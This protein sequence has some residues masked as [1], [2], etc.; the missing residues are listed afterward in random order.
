MDESASDS[1]GEELQLKVNKRFA[2]EFEEKNRKADLLRAERSGLLNKDADSDSDDDDESEDEYANALTP[3]L[4]FDIMKTISMIH[5]KDKRIYDEKFKPFEKGSAEQKS[6]DDGDDDDDDDDDDDE[7]EEMKAKASKSKKK[8][9][10]KKEDKKDKGL[11]YKDLVRQQV[12]KQTENGDASQVFEDSDTEEK[13]HTMDTETVPTYNAEQRRLKDA[14]KAQASRGL[15]AADD[16][17]SD[18]DEDADVLRKKE[19]TKEELE[20]EEDNFKRYMST[21]AKRDPRMRKA[22]KEDVDLLETF[23]KE[24]AKDKDEA[25]LRSFFLNQTWADQ[26]GSGAAFADAANREGADGGEGG[27][28]DDDE[29]DEE[30]LEAADRFEAKYN[31]RHEEPGSTELMETTFDPHSSVRRKESSRKRQ[32]DAKRQRKQEEKE[33]RKEELRRLKNLKRKELEKRLEKSIE[34]AGLSGDAKLVLKPEDLDGDFDPEEFDRKMAA[35]FN[36]AYYDEEDEGFEATGDVDAEKKLF[37][38]VGGDEDEDD[39][40][41][42]GAKTGGATRDDDDEDDD[43]D[44]VKIVERPEDDP[45]TQAALKE[46]EEMDEAERRRKKKRE[47]ALA[48]GGK[49]VSVADLKGKVINDELYKMDYDDVIGG[50]IKTR[51]KY[52]KV[53]PN[54]YG[55][56][57]AEILFADEDLLNSFVSIKR[58]APYVEKEW[59]ATGKHRRRFREALRAREAGLTQR[60]EKKKKRERRKAKKLSAEAE[61]SDAES[62]ADGAFDDDNDNLDKDAE[63]KSAVPRDKK[64]DEDD[65]GEEKKSKKK[66]KKRKRKR[67]H[68]G[69]GDGDGDGDGDEDTSNDAEDKAPKDEDSRGVDRKDN[70]ND[71]GKEKKSKKKRRRKRKKTNDGED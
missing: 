32:R 26:D 51:F 63:A 6:S 11:R 24:P 2:K 29:E 7:K 19:K 25:F 71:D 23:F 36:D 54:S 49:A 31:F 65:E 21:L 30:A 39:D 41:D 40:D 17:D 4:D 20:A 59:I 16:S 61:D 55:L 69:E 9:K 47:K 5:N 50:D 12:L 15:S 10:D 43:D 57:T 68:K 33:R 67:K 38:D 34:M 22:R 13:A 3:K 18:D 37:G 14:F 52:R 1:D 35:M 8:K 27:E 58:M 64:D 46:E 56:T 48:A 60:K 42:D 66:S 45:S 62:A 70:D 44:N 53:T 28:D